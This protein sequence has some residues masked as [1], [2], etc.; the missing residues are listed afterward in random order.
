MT[1][2]QKE[3]V[4]QTARNLYRAGPDDWKPEEGK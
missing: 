2:E 4:K 1:N 3:V